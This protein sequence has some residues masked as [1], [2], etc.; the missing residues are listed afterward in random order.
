MA[1]RVLGMT[2]GTDVVR[3]AVVETRMRRF[4]LRAVHEVSRFAST[5]DPAWAAGEAAEGTEATPVRVAEALTKVLAQPVTSIDSVCLAFPGEQGFV[6]R[7]SF[8]FKNRSSIEAT[9]PMQMVDRVPIQV[10]DIHC[11]FERLPG[12][13]EGTEVLAVAVPRDSLDAFLVQSH[14]DGIDPA[15]VSLDGVCL[16]TL[17]PWLPGASGEQARPLMVVWAEGS[18]AEMLVADRQRTVLARSAA[19]AENVVSRGEV[20][21]AF[22]RETLLSLA[23]ASE[24]GTN[25]EAV[26]VAGPDAETLVGPLGEALGVPASVLY[27]SLLSIPGTGTCEGLS[28][29][30]VKPLALALTAAA[31]GGPGSLNLRCGPYS[32]E[33]AQGLF[34]ERFRFFAVVLAVFVAL[35]IGRAVFRYAG[36][37]QERKAVMAE[38]KAFTA[39]VLGKETDNFE[40]ALKQMKAL[41]EDDVRVFPRWTAVG[42]LD[43]LLKVFVDVGRSRAAAQKADGDGF[44]EPDGA[45]PVPPVATPDDAETTGLAVEI[46]NIRI[47]P[48]SGTVRG[49]A[50]SIETLDALVAKLGSDICFHDVLT[51]STERIQ[52]QR[53]QGWQRFTLRFGIDCTPK[54]KATTAANK[55]TAG[56]TKGPAAAPKAQ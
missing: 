46:E 51:E 21:S 18:R 53:H 39:G 11:A 50:D 10:E 9:L 45:T 17:L 38:L 22:L 43:R 7:L 24:A 35:G 2:V 41:T 5:G 30:F 52:F 1:H 54:T 33:G 40:A 29:A 23:A 14:A 55:G 36:L 27:P 3:V 16:A 48:R 44:G 19:L 56:T 25:V 37:T 4:E 31:G 20:A 12:E 6:R 28:P 15:H 13:S 32:S 34:R 49:E 42:S 8:P 47:D 26:L